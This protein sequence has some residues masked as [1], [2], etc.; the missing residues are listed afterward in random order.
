M[1]QRNNG[2]SNVRKPTGE[3]NPRMPLHLFS[4]TITAPGKDV[5]ASQLDLL[6]TFLT[7]YCTRGG[8]SLEVGARCHNL[9]F[10]G[11]FYYILIYL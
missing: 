3:M 8:F 9:H 11:A 10:Q 5:I 7:T 4:V 6:E 1:F 2:T